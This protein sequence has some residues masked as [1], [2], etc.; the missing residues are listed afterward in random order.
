MKRFGFRSPAVLIR[1]TILQNLQ[2]A[3]AEAILSYNV[4]LV[5]F[6]NIKCSTRCTGRRHR[7]MRQLICD[8]EIVN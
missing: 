8:L 3:P 2:W 7:C 4:V 5:E 1:T 6:N